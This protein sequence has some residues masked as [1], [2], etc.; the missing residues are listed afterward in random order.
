[1]ARGPTVCWRRRREARH[2]ITWIPSAKSFRWWRSSWRL[3][4]RCLKRWHLK[5]S[6]AKA[7][8]SLKMGW[9]WAQESIK[10]IRI[11]RFLQ[12]SSIYRIPHVWRWVW[13][14]TPDN[15]ESDLMYTHGIWK[16]VGKDSRSIGHLD[17]YPIWIYQN[18][19]L[20]Y[21]K[22]DSLIQLYHVDPFSEP[23]VTQCDPPV[24]FHNISRT[25]YEWD[26]ARVIIFVLHSSFKPSNQFSLHKTPDKLWTSSQS[27]CKWEPTGKKPIYT[28]R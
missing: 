6:S 9:F 7:W 26:Q 10:W 22:I 15:L 14:S 4:A 3:K 27:W 1:M 19:A 16:A 12:Q 20:D 13:R 8:L 2:W 17:H 21:T 18:Y 24:H 11:K 28:R 25:T 23:L 5:K